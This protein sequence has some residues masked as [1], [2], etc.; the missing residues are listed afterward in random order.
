M[1]SLQTALRTLVPLQQ[2]SHQPAR[3]LVRALRDEL[4]Q[5]TGGLPLADDTTIVVC[6]IDGK[7]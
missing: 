2:L 7:M 6:R 1:A 4:Q 3:E 5:F